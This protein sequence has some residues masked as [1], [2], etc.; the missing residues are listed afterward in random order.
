M[1]IIIYAVISIDPDKRFSLLKALDR[2][3]DDVREQTGCVRYDWAADGSDTGQINVYEEW[4]DARALDGHFAGSNFAKIVESIGQHG[5]NS[6]SA[7]K[8]S[9]AQEGPVFG[10]DGKPT[11]SF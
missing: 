8:Y 4:E 10:A 11:S 1:K 2:G 7:K 9:I 5:I 3:I 6:M